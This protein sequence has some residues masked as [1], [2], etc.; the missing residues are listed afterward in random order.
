M[1]SK[2][3][4]LI[5]GK[6]HFEKMWEW[7]T[8]GNRSG[9]EHWLPIIDQ[10]ETWNPDHKPDGLWYGEFLKRTNYR[11]QR[12][13]EQTSGWWDSLLTSYNSHIGEHNDNNFSMCDEWDSVASIKQYQY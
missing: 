6:D 8:T 7:A 11:R 10:T 2:Y 4:L 9:A 13:C 1:A 3:Q 12:H 5:K